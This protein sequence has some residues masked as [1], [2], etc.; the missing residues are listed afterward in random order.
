MREIKLKIAEKQVTFY[1]S[2]LTSQP[3]KW[4]EIARLKREKGNLEEA[5][6]EWVNNINKRSKT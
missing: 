6:I 1:L 5:I 3:N 2:T 4:N